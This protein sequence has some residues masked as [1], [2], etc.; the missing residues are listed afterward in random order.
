MTMFKE[1][2]TSLTDILIAIKE[3]STTP[4]DTIKH[5]ASLSMVTE[6]RR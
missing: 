6:L 1:Y 2:S 5:F 4:Q 3:E